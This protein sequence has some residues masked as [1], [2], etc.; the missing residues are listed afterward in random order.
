MIE[1]NQIW[2]HHKV[3]LLFAYCKTA[4]RYTYI[5][6]QQYSLVQFGVKAIAHSPDLSLRPSKV[7]LGGEQR[8]NDRWRRGDHSLTT[9][10]P[11]GDES[12]ERGSDPSAQ[13]DLY[14]EVK[15]Y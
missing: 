10:R 11:E 12:A 1:P 7:I 2:S 8:K 9:S 4:K 13:A 5:T 3:S 14:D 6:I 15:K